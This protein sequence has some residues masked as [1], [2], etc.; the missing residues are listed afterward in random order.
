MSS[1]HEVVVGQPWSNQRSYFLTEIAAPPDPVTTPC[2]LTF[3][4]DLRKA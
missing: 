4:M 3:A 1:R 2:A